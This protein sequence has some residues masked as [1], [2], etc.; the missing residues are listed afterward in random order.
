MVLLD[1][2]GQRWTLRILWELTSGPASFRDLQARCDGVSPSVMNT[3]LKTLRS[4]DL[5]ERVTEG[6]ALTR[7]GRQLGRHLNKLNA[8][9]DEWARGFDPT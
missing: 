8:W 3:R 5:V 9:A 4:L 6:Y 2:L 1:V 7:Q